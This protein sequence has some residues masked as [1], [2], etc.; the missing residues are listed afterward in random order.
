MHAATARIP[1]GAGRQAKNYADASATH[2]SQPTYLPVK[3][4]AA[5]GAALNL[6]VGRQGRGPAGTPLGVDEGVDEPV[7]S[8]FTV[9]WLGPAVAGVLRQ[10]TTPTHH[11]N[12][13]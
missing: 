11:V 5:R 8:A 10:P 12:T 1:Q 4:C 9:F 7:D 13:T 3:R 2:V 6:W